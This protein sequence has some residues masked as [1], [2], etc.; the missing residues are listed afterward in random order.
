MAKNSLLSRF[1]HFSGL[2]ADDDAAPET[3][4][5]KVDDKV[6]DLADDQDDTKDDVSDHEERISACESRLDALEADDGDNDGDDMDGANAKADDDDQVD[7]YGSKAKGSKAYKAG[8]NAERIRCSAIFADPSAA[9]NPVLAAEIAFNSGM[10]A[11]KAI[12]L[13]KASSQAAPAAKPGL[14][15]R[16]AAVT[17]IHIKP[18]AGPSEPLSAAQR[19]AA[20]AARINS[21]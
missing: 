3:D 11:A 15:A 19:L 18:E 5:T 8:R 2:A 20:A 7:D 21:K 16:M 10:S 17:P 14:A 1:A 13:L 4:V 12:G 6:N 9:A